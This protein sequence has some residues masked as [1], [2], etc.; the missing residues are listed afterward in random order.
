MHGHLQSETEAPVSKCASVHEVTSIRCRR[1][2]CPALELNRWSR[3]SVSDPYNYFF[4]VFKLNG[5]RMHSKPPA[6]SRNVFPF[7]TRCD[8]LTQIVL[9][10]IVT[11]FGCQSQQ[12]DHVEGIEVTLTDENFDQEVL[13]SEI[14]VL[15]DFNATWCGPCKYM[16][17]IVATLS[18]DF[19][20]RA[21]V[22]KLDVENSPKTPRQYEI[23]GIPA[24]LI[25]KDG[26]VVGRI[27]GTES[28]RALAEL[29]ES[30]IDKPTNASLE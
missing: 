28:Y 7:R 11:S 27:V 6:H 17:P 19:A 30:F 24:F 16:D 21:K 26:E 29:L 9:V 5:N 25:F 23:N 14:P 15:V 3:N 2:T 20:G 22:G 12:S 13:K 1:I 4:D 10:A 18:N 8:V